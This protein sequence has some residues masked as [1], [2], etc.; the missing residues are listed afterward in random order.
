LSNWPS[1]TKI[2]DIFNSFLFDEVN[3]IVL[4]H[5]HVR[6]SEIQYDA[7]NVDIKYTTLD[8]EEISKIDTELHKIGYKIKCVNTQQIE[9]NVDENIITVDGVKFSLRVIPID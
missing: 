5:S 7:Y 9:I 6:N 4:L 1:T 3:G 8:F 2:Q